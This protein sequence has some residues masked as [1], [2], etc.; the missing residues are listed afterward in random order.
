MPRKRR[1]KYEGAWYHV[2]SRGINRNNI[3]FENDD[4]YNFLDILK[5]AT[6][7]YT[8]ECHAYCLMGN[9]YHL[10]IHTPLGNISD[11]MHYIN[12][13]HTRYVN[14]QQNR[15]GPLFRNR[16]HA[17]LM[18]D[19]AYLLRVVR[20]IHQNPLKAKFVEDLKKYRWSS[21]LYYIEDIFTH[22]WLVQDQ[23][24]MRFRNLKYNGSFE[25]FTE[26][27]DDEEISY[28][29]KHLK[30]NSILMSSEELEKIKLHKNL[31]SLS[32]YLKR[33]DIIKSSKI[34]SLDQITIA[35]A[36]YFSI[37]HS[38]L[39]TDNQFKKKNLAR[40]VAIYLCDKLNKSTHSEIAK[41]MGN[42]TRSTITTLLTKAQG[43]AE[44]HYHANKVETINF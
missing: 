9:H 10:V 13:M 4:R 43:D 39:L 5:Q 42:V 3:F 2:M 21:Y 6:E 30:Y 34:P 7:N 19:E 24:K 25:K 16:Y 15:T 41:H 12:N 31:T 36:D 23:V 26:S 40:R 29:F 27:T 35:T 11:A 17:I 20:Y 28:F 1:I 14:K 44:V 37:S 38:R 22:D 8:I 33:N 18:S 32:T